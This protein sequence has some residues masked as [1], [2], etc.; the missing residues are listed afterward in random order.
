MRLA[1]PLVDILPIAA[2]EVRQQCDSTKE[3][4]KVEAD[5][6]APRIPANA[7]NER[8]ILMRVALQPRDESV[9]SVAI[10]RDSL[11]R[12]AP[13]NRQSPPALTDARAVR[14]KPKLAVKVR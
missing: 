4:Q 13:P 3:E 12:N 5:H 6:I 11:A 1:R 9:R 7:P 14:F 10:L 8:C 2:S